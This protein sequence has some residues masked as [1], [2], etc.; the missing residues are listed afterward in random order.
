MTRGLGRI[1]PMRPHRET[2]LSSGVPGSIRAM[3]SHAFSHLRR[4]G[5]SLLVIVNVC[6]FPL[7]VSR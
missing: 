1:W 3:P 5:A 2:D 6:G 7:L 4:L